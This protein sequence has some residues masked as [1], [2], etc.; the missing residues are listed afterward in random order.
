MGTIIS[1]QSIFFLTKIFSGSDLFL[2]FWTNYFSKT[3][4]L[5]NNFWP[6]YSYQYIL[7]GKPVFGTSIF[8]TK[9]FWDQKKWVLV[10]GYQVSSGSVNSFPH[11]LSSYLLFNRRSLFNMY[12]CPSV[13]SGSGGVSLEKAQ[14]ASDWSSYWGYRRGGHWG[15]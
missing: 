11:K 4:F 10:W 8:W 15:G 14:L 2:F 12:Y 7:G 9:I 13:C 3:S 6:F 5:F 1:M